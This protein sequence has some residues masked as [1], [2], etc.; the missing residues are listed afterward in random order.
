MGNLQN[1]LKRGYLET[2]LNRRYGQTVWHRRYLDCLAQG[3]LRII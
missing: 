3:I 1:V 2:F